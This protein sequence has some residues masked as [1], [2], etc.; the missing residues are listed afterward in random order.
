MKLV[1]DMLIERAA[2]NEVGLWV[3]VDAED[4]VLV[5]AESLQTL[6]R[7]HVPDLDGL[8]VRARADIFRV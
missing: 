3:E 7:R 2:D 5:A 4:V 8:V 6:A 1:P